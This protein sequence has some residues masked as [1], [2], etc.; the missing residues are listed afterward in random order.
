MIIGET[1][2]PAGDVIKDGTDESFMAD[3][4]E[5]SKDQP[6]IV[7]FWAP[8]CGPCKQLGPVLERV[9]AAQNGKVRLVKIDTDKHPHFAGQLRVQSIP[10]VYAFKAG[11]PVDA[12][13]GALP[14][15]QVKAFVQ[16]LLVSAEAGEM[17]V[18]GAL[19]AAAQ[20]MAE[21]NVDAAGD[22]YAALL[23]ADQ[24]NFKAV[25]GLVRCCLLRGEADRAEH[26]TR[27]L[28]ADAKDADLDAARTAVRLAEAAP[29]DVAG[30]EKRVAEDGDDFVGRMELARALAGLARYDKA[31]EQLFAVV[32][33]DR[34][35]NGG[36]ARRVLLEVFEA[37][38]LT[39]DV[40]R[41]GRRRLSSI[42][43]A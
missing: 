28:P 39:S 21:G 14:E 31:A 37:A 11:K 43:F 6:V 33:K 24:N 42:L 38:G 7:D 20:A 40:A 23:Q 26:L 13:M 17:D 25:A 15:S 27:M 1:K 30:L 4:V 34:D 3:V 36:Q 9:I 35:W 22:M 41:N 5:A 18:E 10:V 2:A 19:A 16:K 29:K 8:W 12:F 32:E